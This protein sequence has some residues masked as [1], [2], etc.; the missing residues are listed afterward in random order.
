LVVASG[1]QGEPMSALARI[2]VDKHREVEIE[3]GDL[4]IHSARQI[5]G[6]EKSV[7]RMF[8]HLMR[9]GADVVTAT[10]R[11]VHVSG[12]AS[13]AELQ[14]LLQ[15]LRP[16]YIVPIHGEYR[17]LRAHAQLAFDC[18]MEQNHVQLADSGD[19][20]VV[21]PRG[22]GV[23]DRI[24]VGQV[25]IDADLGEVDWEILRER[26]RIAG[27]GIVVP[28]VAVHRESGAVNGFPEIMTRGFVPAGDA[29]DE[30]VMQ[31]A[32]RLVAASLDDA[33][34]EERGD[35]GLLRAR[36]QTDLKRYFRRRSQRPPLVIPIIVEL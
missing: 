18:G 16:K 11:Q 28:V 6:N 21:D 8:N 9:R 12:H 25:F 24:H 22:I 26:R 33:S 31:E 4:V 10:E 36:I 34:P 17:Q 7:G 35:E 3:P 2:A 5:P 29:G 32:R 19:V 14:L 23:E 20:I 27:G 15:L 1:S 13:R 30:D